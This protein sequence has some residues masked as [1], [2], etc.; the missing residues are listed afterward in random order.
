[1][2]GA[3]VVTEVVNAADS[4]EVS[5]SIYVNLRMF[6]QEVKA[7]ENVQRVLLFNGKPCWALG[8]GTGELSHNVLTEIAM[9]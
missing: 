7:P 1:M 6:A 9:T 8:D 2:G 4:K 5:D 3:K